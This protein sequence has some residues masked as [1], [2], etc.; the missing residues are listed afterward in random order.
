[1]SISPEDLTIGRKANARAK[2]YELQKPK[3]LMAYLVP[4]IWAVGSLA[5]YGARPNYGYLFQ[6]VFWSIALIGVIIFEYR[7][8]QSYLRDL[9]TLEGLRNLHG[10]DISFEQENVASSSGDIS[11]G[12]PKKPDKWKG[13]EPLVA[14]CTLLAVIFL[15]P[16]VFHYLLGVYTKLK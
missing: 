16:L 6:L 13:F 11:A 12:A 8:N 15:L 3:R 5:R 9:A 4:A 7:N 2:K 1:M 10:S 14:F